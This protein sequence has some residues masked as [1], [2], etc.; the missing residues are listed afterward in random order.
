M[1]SNLTSSIG[2]NKT[3]CP[4]HH[5]ASSYISSSSEVDP[6]LLREI[7]ASVSEFDPILLNLKVSIVL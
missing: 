4:I 5:L 6:L 7:S 2:M 3:E 1:V